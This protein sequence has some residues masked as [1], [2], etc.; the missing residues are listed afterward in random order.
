[1]AALPAF[2]RTWVLIIGFVVL[3]NSG[4]IGAEYALPF[5][6]PLTLLL[7]R[8][9]SL[10]II[11]L[12]YLLARNRLKWPGWQATSIAG[13]IGVLAHGTW[14]GCVFY[15][16]E[17]GVPSGIVA[18]VVAL[19]PMTTGLFSGMVAGERTPPIRW[20]GLLIGFGGVMIAVTTRMEFSD[21]D[22][23]FA[24]LIP[25]GSVAAITVASL[26]QRR[27][28]V[29]SHDYSLPVDLG[30]FY[31]SMG[32]ALAVS[33][34]AI[35]F[36]GLATEWTPLFLGGLAWLTLVVS[37]GAYGLMWILIERIDATRVASLFYFGPPVTMLMAWLAFDDGLLPTDIIGLGVI[38]AGVG[39]AQMKLSSP[40]TETGIIRE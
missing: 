38:A 12:V 32:V 4:F 35:L 33:I 29:K 31:Q 19:Q 21:P 27:L 10:A 18:L 14:L 25:F 37:L 3:W 23:I 8:Y 13:L 22:S 11:L 36:E 15:S 7:W 40:A 2:Q 5:T 26:I 20:I 1:M 16:L 28:H 9:W 17:Y 39:L 24:Y 34:P 6:E 30:L